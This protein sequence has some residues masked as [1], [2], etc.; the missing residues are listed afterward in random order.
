MNSAA[1]PAPA[2]RR[3]YFDCR[4][5]QLHVYQAI[6]SGGGFDE[7]TAVICVPGA[8]GNAVV[9]APWL[10][11]LGVDRS[12]YAPDLPGNGMS[13]AARG[14]TRTDNAAAAVSDF[15]AAARAPP[16]AAAATAAGLR[17]AARR[18]AGAAT[19]IPRLMP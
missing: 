14:G 4:F 17:A 2:V 16:H 9:F 3:A 19:T 18:A 11:L 15:M 8:D 1:R 10:P 12:M 5:G 6:P 7:A 13:D